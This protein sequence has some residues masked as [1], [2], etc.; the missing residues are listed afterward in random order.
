[1]LTFINALTI[2]NS[3]TLIAKCYQILLGKHVLLGP[4][5]H[6]HYNLYVC[7]ISKS[8]NVIQCKPE[9]IINSNHVYLIDTVR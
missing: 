1:M 4:V 8:I 9:S 6:M 5:R 2:V 3:C 7:R